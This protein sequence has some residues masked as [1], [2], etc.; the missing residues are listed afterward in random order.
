M[1]VVPD[2][3]RDPSPDAARAGQPLGRRER[4]KAA[5]RQSL[6]EAAF[7]L[8]AAQGY[9]ETTL[10][11]ITDAA[12]VAPRT[13]FRYFASKEELILG[14]SAEMEAS[15]GALLAARPAGEPVLEAI[16]AALR[17]LDPEGQGTSDPVQREH[18]LLRFR[19]MG[20]SPAV[21]AGLLDSYGAMERAIAAFVAAR[22]GADATL[23]VGPSMVAASVVA[24][25]RVSLTC[26]A[27]RGGGDDVEELFAEAVGLAV[28]GLRSS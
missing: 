6:E 18:L 2:H 17:G 15:L 8:F 3:R 21:R 25:V 1:T 16:L 10:Q 19:I 4:K 11:D 20:E 26:W 23:D 24:A 22:S 5:T 14:S 9:D 12:D 13:F 7:R 28:G 27:A